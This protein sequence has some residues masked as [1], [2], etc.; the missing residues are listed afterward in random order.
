ME[1]PLNSRQPAMQRVAKAEHAG[2]VR[3][4]NRTDRS[5]QQRT[6]NSCKHGNGDRLA[7]DR[8][9]ADRLIENGLGA[10]EIIS[11]ENS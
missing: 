6:G 2:D 1:L 3:W 7:T 4:I 8:L 10:K 11:G 5:C 9:A